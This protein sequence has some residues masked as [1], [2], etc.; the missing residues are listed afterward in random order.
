MIETWTTPVTRI[1]VEPAD[2]D[3]YGETMPGAEVQEALPAG[4][5]APGASS[6]PVA[7]GA[8]P[9]I[10]APTVYWPGQWPDVLA[11]DVLLIG[12][13]RYQVEGDPAR[14]PMGLVVTLRAVTEAQS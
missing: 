1:R 11:S 13:V 3:Q 10:T 7:P 9:V 5:F 8:A 14:W 12:G 4:L 2:V 6:E